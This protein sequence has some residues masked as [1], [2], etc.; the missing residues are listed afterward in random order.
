ML[1]CHSPHYN[2]KKKTCTQT[3]HKQ[4][5]ILNNHIAFK[6]KAIYISILN[7]I[8]QKIIYKQLTHPI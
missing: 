1:Q 4:H 3:E 2:R 8:D 6:D 5:N 7:M